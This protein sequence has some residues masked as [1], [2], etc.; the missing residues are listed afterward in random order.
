MTDDDA[1]TLYDAAGNSMPVGRQCV[2]LG[3]FTAYSVLTTTSCVRLYTSAGC[4]EDAAP[5]CWIVEPGDDL[6]Y[7]DIYGPYVKS[8]VKL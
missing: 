6:T 8:A 3:V 7:L 4:D 5:R 1:A 2:D